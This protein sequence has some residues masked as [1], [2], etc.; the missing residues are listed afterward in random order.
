LLG[1]G[2]DLSQIVGEA[3]RCVARCSGFTQQAQ[4]LCAKID[5]GAG[6]LRGCSITFP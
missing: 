2:E 3:E 5:G 4:V 6:L 1:L